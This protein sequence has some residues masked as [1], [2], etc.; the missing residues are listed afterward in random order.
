MIR[1]FYVILFVLMGFQFA[2]NLNVRAQSFDGLHELAR[3]HFNVN[4]FDSALY[5]Y[6]QANSIAPENFKMYLLFKQGS[7]AYELSSYE[8][9]IQYWDACVHYHDSVENFNYYSIRRWAAEGLINVYA[10]KR[11]YRAVIDWAKRMEVFIRADGGC[12]TGRYEKM[13]QV[14]FK[15]STA[16]HH[17]HLTDSAIHFL[18]PYMFGNEHELLLDSGE[19]QS[20]VVQYISWLQQAGYNQEKL[21][22]Q[23]QEAVKNLQVSLLPAMNENTCKP[24]PWLTRAKAYTKFI[25]IPV[26]LVNFEIVLHTWGEHHPFTVPRMQEIMRSSNLYK[27]LVLDGGN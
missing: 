8:E 25:G 9:A 16:Y 12:G 13:M 6:K 10:K 27:T 1:R 17:L 26:H 20:Y 5:Y 4:Q 24:D 19:Y 11:E 2:V 15:K 22:T 23:L 14:V 7:S 21:R 18:T 3:R